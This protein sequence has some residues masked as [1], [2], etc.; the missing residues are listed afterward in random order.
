MTPELQK[1]I[2]SIKEWNLLIKY[3]KT[4]L[5]LSLLEQ[6]DY[7]NYEIQD[8][9][10]SKNIHIYP[11]I[12]EEK[13]HF[14]CIPCEFDSEKYKDTIANY[15]KQCNVYKSIQNSN[16]ITEEEALKRIQ[17][18]KTYLKEWLPKQSHTTNGIFKAYIVPT[19][20]LLN[21][22]KVFAYFALKNNQSDTQFSADLIL[23]KENNK[24]YDTV[25]PVPPFDPID[26]L[27]L[28][29]SIEDI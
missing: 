8:I 28:L 27:F 13:L 6:G 7:F 5:I 24:Y 19:E 25:R 4:D 3:E 23:K 14:Y 16:E 21:S 10:N 2:E 20:D 17:N 15:I 26:N 18:W 11:G 9:E 12:T 1:I 29:N 22:D